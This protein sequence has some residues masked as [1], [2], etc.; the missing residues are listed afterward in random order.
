[1]KAAVTM[2]ASRAHNRVVGASI[3]E[4]LAPCAR[5]TNGDATLDCVEAVMEEHHHLPESLVQ[6]LAILAEAAHGLAQEGK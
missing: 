6:Q 5:D 4:L 3:L 2:W 1:L